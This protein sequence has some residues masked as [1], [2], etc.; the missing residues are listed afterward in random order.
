MNK[1]AIMEKL[2]GRKLFIVL[3]ILLIAGILAALMMY[4]W[5]NGEEKV[6]FEI[7]KN[8]EIPKDI[9]LNVIPEYRSMERALACVIDDQVYVIVTRGEKPTSGFQ[10][11]VDEILLDEKDG[12]S[13]LI[14]YADFKDPEKKNIISQILTYPVCVVKTELKS[15]PD[16]VEL[17]IQYEGN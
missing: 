13:N 5:F 9:S 7:A 11:S 8:A 15:L 12:K 4:R 3:A 14:V 6:G 1:T 16:T 2:Q 10:V 17:R